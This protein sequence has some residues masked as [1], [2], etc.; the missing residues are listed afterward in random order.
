MK[1]DLHDQRV[2]HII[3]KFQDTKKN[4]NIL[5]LVGGEEPRSYAK[6]LVIGMAPNL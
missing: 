5:N 1:K 6:R 3:I 4:G 2:R